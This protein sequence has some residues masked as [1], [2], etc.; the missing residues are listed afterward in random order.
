MPR[1][2]GVRTADR[3]LLPDEIVRDGDPPDAGRSTAGLGKTILGRRV[4]TTPSKNHSRPQGKSSSTHITYG[5]IRQ[6]PRSPLGD[7][8]ERVYNRC[9]PPLGA[10]YD[11]PG[12]TSKTDSLSLD[13]TSRLDPVCPLNGIKPKSAVRGGPLLR[14]RGGVIPEVSPV[15]F[16]FL[17]VLV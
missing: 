9:R 15:V 13:G 10:R 6:P 2:T 16:F 12:S 4:G 14:R 1:G 5:R 7:W 11:E 3:R 17:L 8:I